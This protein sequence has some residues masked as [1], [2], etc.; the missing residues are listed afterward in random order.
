[1]SYLDVISKIL[2]SKDVTVGGG[3]TSAI[4]GAF[5]A[6]L[7]GMV[8]RLSISTKKNYGLSLAEYE[9]IADDL[10]Q[11]NRELLKGSEED[12]KAYLLIK[13][14]YSL[15]KTTDEEK[16]IRAKAIETAGI[17]AAT[18]PRQ[19]GYLCKKVYSLGSTL[20]NNSN[21]AAYSDLII[22]V[23]LAKLGI[24][25]CIMNIEANIPLIKDDKIKE[26]FEKHIRVLKGE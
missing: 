7:I 5:A 14:A 12:T 17:A 23:K 19:N 1:M 13:D 4:S 26:E 9:A 2:D 24:E 15:P 3:S 20:I 21:G 22:G 25:G 18:V 10:D 8:S 16:L 6:G 11:L